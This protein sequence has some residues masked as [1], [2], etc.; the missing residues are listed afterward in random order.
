LLAA[1]PIGW[2]QWGQTMRGGK[3]DCEHSAQT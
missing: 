3:T 1:L 2:W